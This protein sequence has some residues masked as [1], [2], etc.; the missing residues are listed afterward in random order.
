M[1]KYKL[2]LVFILTFISVTAFSQQ[3]PWFTE[4]KKIDAGSYTVIFPSEIESR[5]QY[6][7]NLLNHYE[8]YNY[9]SLRTSP[10]KIPVV[11][12]NTY[13]VSNGFVSFSPF[14]SHWFTTP[15]GLTGNEWLKTLA[16]HE[17]RHMTQQNK[18]R[19]GAGKKTWNILLG[20]L[21]TAAFTAL[22]IPFWF[23]EGDAV[24]METAHTDYGR[25]R[26]A[27][28]TLWHRALELSGIRYSYY[29]TFLGTPDDLYPYNDYYRSGYLVTSYTRGKYGKQ[30]WD[31]ILSRTGKYIL[32]PAFFRSVYNITGEDV[33]DIYNSAMDSYRDIWMEQ[34]KNVKLS[35]YRK[36]T[37]KIDDDYWRAFMNPVMLNDESARA[38]FF[39]RDKVPCIVKL[40]TEGVIEKKLIQLPF[41]LLSSSFI[42]ERKFGFGGDKF[43]YIEDSSDPRWGYRSYSDLKFYDLKL[44]KFKRL[45]TN[46]KYISANISRD[47]TM[48]CGIEY[49][50]DLK[51]KIRIFNLE[52]GS[53]I[54]TF[55]I[56]R[57]SMITDPAFSDSKKEIAIVCLDDKGYCISEMDL[58]TGLTKNIT[59]SSKTEKISTPVYSGKNIIYISDYS[60][61]DNIYS[62]EMDTG[63]RYQIFSSKFGAYY[64]SI[65]SAENTIIFNN[66]APQGYTVASIKID[67][68]K[69]I[70]IKNVKRNSD[71]IIESV[72]NQEYADNTDLIEKRDNIPDTKYKTEKYYPILNLINPMGWIPFFDSTDSNFYFYFLSRDVLQT[73]D[74]TLG[75]VYNTNEK[76]HA[77]EG[78][79]LYM[80]LYPVFSVTGGY[81]K[82]SV[83]IDTGTSDDP[84]YEQMNWKEE[85]LFFSVK[86]PLNIVSGINNST[87]N[88]ESGY[89]IINISDKNH[90]TH[91]IYDGIYKDGNLEYVNGLLNFQNYIEYPLNCVGPRW[92]QEVMAS[93]FSTRNDSDF[94][95]EQISL[96]GKLYFPGI[97]ETNSFMISA[98]YEQNLFENY[99]F[100]EQ[101]LFPRG[102]KSERHEKFYKISLD[103]SF[104]I[105]SLSLPVWRLVY[106][107]RLKG[108]IFYDRGTGFTGENRKTYSSAGVEVTSTVNLLSN[109]LLLL[110]I[111]ARYSKCFENGENVFSFILKTPI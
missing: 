66:Y 63:K 42:N 35:Q 14:Y 52:D 99:I 92:G 57:Y 23:L 64:P 111:G 103:Y 91:T 41:S 80:G 11:L 8:K 24:L 43:I 72:I 38:M 49:G 36:V 61:V 87:F 22:Y 12:I 59:G 6:V 1:H 81:G 19:D 18:L 37:H 104:P 84:I 15:S 106:F 105:I 51:F 102:Y 48:A 60:G 75:Y 34:L 56:D 55:I 54:K 62:V 3:V 32:F 58:N 7:A 45:S 98:A 9:N 4:W 13:S 74:M 29:R 86:L 101:F 96:T 30:I 67:K 47:G 69:W 95:G 17:G 10:R 94:S 16:I 70:S 28:F 73:T 76:T 108:N 31:K 26:I 53:L 100:P 79:I 25:G 68:K 65:N 90:S 97:L 82:R 110:D 85:K 93:I 20:D 27:N 109:Y 88:I 40:S 39:S 89:G 71:R 44:K 46:G 83:Q 21:G 33:R 5:A 50:E 77:V 2:F 78:S 107:K